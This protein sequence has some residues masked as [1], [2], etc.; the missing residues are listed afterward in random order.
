MALSASGQLFLVW[1][2]M[3]D[4]FVETNDK[5]SRQVLEPPP[6]ALMGKAGKY[7]DSTG[8]KRSSFLQ[9]ILAPWRNKTKAFGDNQ[10][11]RI[12]SHKLRT[13]LSILIAH[14]Y[15]IGA[16]KL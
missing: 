11:E 16:K 2:Y 13:K 6:H 8:I 12:K 9:S 5:S 7:L 1:V 3:R 14:N 15:S 4:Y 10:G